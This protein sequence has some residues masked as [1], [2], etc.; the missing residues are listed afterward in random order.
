MRDAPMLPDHRRCDELFADAETAA[1]EGIAEAATEAFV[2]LAV[3]M[4]THLGAE[5]TL[6][7]PEFKA[8]TGMSH[9]GPSAPNHC[10][11]GACAHVVSRGA[12]WSPAGRRNHAVRSMMVSC[13]RPLPAWAERQASL[14]AGR[15]WLLTQTVRRG[16][17]C[18]AAQRA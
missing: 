4:Q 18:Q 5:Q 9:D 3:A 2:D 13:N 15:R 17:V 1:H 16:A 11:F 14:R 12:A 6:R 7:F 8:T 10:G